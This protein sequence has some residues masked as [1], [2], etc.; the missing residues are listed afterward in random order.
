M[1]RVL[2]KIVI[3][4]ITAAVVG[5]PNGVVMI[6]D[7]SE[8]D[9]S[10]CSS[11]GYVDD[12]EVMEGER[13]N[14]WL[15]E[16]VDSVGEI[17]GY[18]SLALDSN[19][20]PRISYYSSINKEVKYVVYSED[21]WHI[22]VL[23]SVGYWGGHTSISIDSLDK[24]HLCYHDSEDDTL[25]YT[26]YNGNQ[27]N[28]EIVD[29]ISSPGRFNSMILNSLDQ[30]H[31][32]YSSGSTRNIKHAFFN[33]NQW[34]VEVVDS[35][36]DIGH[37][38]SISL[39]INNFPHISYIDY[40]NNYLK[41]TYH[42]GNQWHTEIIDP[43]TEVRFDT[44][45]ALN[46]Q[47]I[48]YICYLDTNNS[49]L[50]LA[51]LD[52]NQWHIDVVD[53]MI[54]VTMDVSITFDKEDKLHLSY[55]DD[56]NDDL[57]Y[58]LFDGTKWTMET[59]DSP[60]N[61]GYETSIS[62]DGNGLPH[63]S[64][65][66]ASNE[67][68]K[69]AMMLEKEPPLSSI[70][71]VK[72]F[73]ILEQPLPLTIAAT[74]NISG[75]RDVEL[76]YRYSDDNTT[77]QDWSLFGKA[78]SVPYAFDFSFPDGNGYYELYSAATDRHGNTEIDLETDVVRCGYDTEKPTANA[79]V[80]AVLPI[81][82]TFSFDASET[83]DNLGITQYSWHFEDA[84]PQTL[85][86]MNPNYT[87]DNVGIF[88]VTLEVVDGA[89]FR[90][91]DTVTVTVYDDVL[92][93]ADAGDDREIME[94]DTV[95]LDGSSSMDNVGIV[96]YTWSFMY[97]DYEKNLSG[98][99]VEFAFLKPGVYEIMLTVTDEA[100]NTASD[101]FNLTVRDITPPE[102]KAAFNGTAV[103]PGGTY[104]TEVNTTI[105]LNASAS[106][107]NAGIVNFTWEIDDP[108]GPQE[109]EGAAVEYVFGKPGTYTVTLRIN[110]AEG[111]I[112]NLAFDVVVNKTDDGI[113][114]GD[115]PGNGGNSRNGNETG[116]G[117]GSGVLMWVVVAICSVVVAI[118]VVV[119]FAIQG[120]SR[121]NEGWKK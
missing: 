4:L 86:G 87:F 119:L 58:A 54:S 41:Y 7:G 44:A 72:P 35:S 91:I 88:E 21:S 101:V 111:N 118:V 80:D 109:L 28:N 14:D 102:P 110:D 48:P 19:F 30:P 115:V 121:D 42:D 60:E 67:M 47:D 78:E 68:L 23:D 65:V 52:G 104:R 62:I 85:Y 76:W 100:G 15:I 75:I 2:L 32:S 89:A 38:T 92:P 22:E 77:W 94:G 69:Y 16:T 49:K 37:G 13:D 11:V 79:G 105:T 63:I 57:K 82:D 66:D 34:Q 84:G 113:P 106:T 24:S 59:I 51:Y 112:G 40:G 71:P 108:G 3:I 73:W 97:D 45:L 120:K 107:D 33:G 9:G 74:D 83:W 81:G 116:G 6:Q 70:E 10:E 31:I 39:D 5:L 43:T 50:K 12:G 93:V 1:R 53:P 96:D 90:D 99:I 56:T 29:A 18:T 103:E 117:G 17:G 25:K 98:E 20:Q 114:G 64:Y 55:H 46:S 26:C 95:I 36:G 27:W 61:V 8:S